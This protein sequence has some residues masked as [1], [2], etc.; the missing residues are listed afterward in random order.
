MT[1]GTGGG[2]FA[3]I[4]GVEQP[5]ADTFVG[6]ALDAGVNYFDT[7]DVYSLGEAEK[8]LGKALGARRKDV[9]LASKVYSRMGPGE[10]QTG[11]TRLHIV[12]AVEASLQRLN[13]DYL[14]LYQIHGF[15]PLTPLE[16]TMSALTDL[17]RQ[18]KV[19]YIGC[20][21]LAAWQIVKAQEAAARHQFEKFVTVQ[22]YYALVGREL[23]R[24]IIPMALD[25]KIGVL[26][27]SPLAG[28]L[29][30][31]NFTRTGV[32]DKEARRNKIP[33][34]PVNQQRAYQII[35]TLQAVAGRRNATVAQIAL[36][37]LLH[38]PGVTAVIMGAK[39]I[40]Q[41]KDNLGA[42]NVILDA[43]DL[44]QLD[45]VS[46]L[47]PEYPS[48]MFSIQQAARRPEQAPAWVKSMARH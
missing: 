10:N 37:W 36:A 17:V 27:W 5:E 22:A 6:A 13:T 16:E 1:F 39:K 24:E 15:D 38:Q 29:L 40:G 2:N 20:S 33:F 30:S 43:D 47:T 12:Q 11:L 48:W 28:G 25:Q 21:N 8:I 23:E 7:A 31:G 46:H 44:K 26:V 35:E 32:V 3:I 41:L 45:E 14:D 42:V 19:R 9:V 18:G 4:A 34:P